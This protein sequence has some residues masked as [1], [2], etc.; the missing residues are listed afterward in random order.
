ML[1]DYAAA[2]IDCPLLVTTSPVYW[3]GL[4]MWSTASIRCARQWRYLHQVSSE[5]ILD[6]S[7]HPRHS[8][9]YS[10]I[11]AWG[12]SAS[13]VPLWTSLP[14][15]GRFKRRRQLTTP[16]FI[17]CM[18]ITFWLKCNCSPVIFFVSLRIAST[19]SLSIFTLFL[20]FTIPSLRGMLIFTFLLVIGNYIFRIYNFI[21]VFGARQ[22][23]R[24][25]EELKLHK[26]GPGAWS[27]GDL[28]IVVGFINVCTSSFATMVPSLFSKSFSCD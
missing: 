21:L 17:P 11:G 27:I 22:K 23:W 15:N 19:A 3:A 14:F 10:C 12:S 4:K 8:V 25:H 9:S 5:Q 20:V 13:S 18:A 1:P 26:N 16:T 6:G 24:H 7:S 28:F 2:R